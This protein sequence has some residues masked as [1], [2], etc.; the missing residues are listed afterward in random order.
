[1]LICNNCNSVNEDGVVRCVHCHMEGDFRLQMGENRTDDAPLLQNKVICRNCGSD[2]PGEGSRCMHCRFPVART[3]LSVATLKAK[4]ISL[5]PAHIHS[6][7][8]LK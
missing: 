6:Q 5:Q 1:M 2:E 7:A 8:K 4:A 3:E